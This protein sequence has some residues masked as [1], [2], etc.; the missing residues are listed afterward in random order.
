MIDVLRQ[1]EGFL[2]QIDF[3]SVGNAPIFGI[4]L[5]E[6]NEQVRGR[7]E[8]G[9]NLL[10]L[11]RCNAEEPKL[12]FANKLTDSRVRRRSQSEWSE[13]IASDRAKLGIAC[14][15]VGNFC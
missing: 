3:R 4:S 6:T 10:F 7:R 14:R 13:N 11:P 2:L 1:N 9:E 12:A 8:R 15:S 5:E